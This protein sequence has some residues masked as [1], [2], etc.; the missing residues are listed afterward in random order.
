L[1]GDICQEMM[2]DAS[3][4]KYPPE[5][6]AN[7]IDYRWQLSEKNDASDDKNEDAERA[8]ACVPTKH[9]RSPRERQSIFSRHARQEASSDSARSTAVIS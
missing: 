6:A 5:D 2:I 4:A 9:Y 8:A 7:G 1:H 3:F